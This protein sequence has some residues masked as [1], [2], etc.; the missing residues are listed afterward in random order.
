MDKRRT[1]SQQLGV[2]PSSNNAEN[3]VASKAMLFGESRKSFNWSF[4][5][6]RINDYAYQND[7]LSKEECQ[8]IVKLGK[9]K[10][11]LQG[12]VNNKASVEANVR[13]SGVSW[14]APS[15]NLEWLYRRLTDTITLL[16]K[17]FFGFDLY[18]IQEGLQFT[19]YEA[20]DGKYDYHMDR[21]FDYQIRKLSITIQLS[22]PKDYTGGELELLT[23]TNPIAM[24]KKRGKLIIFPSFMLHRVK[25]VT[26]GERNSL[27]VWIAG[28]Q[29][30]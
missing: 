15:D 1:S 17:R 16:N 9:S 13:K 23:G 5:L 29:F 12:K 24:E 21:S 10:R 30:K 18:G 14:L 4:K 3:C 19:N 6:D 8:T 28:S 26:K 11:L 7:F 20:P 25:P 22:N 2:I 27:V